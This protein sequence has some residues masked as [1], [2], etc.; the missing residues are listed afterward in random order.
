MTPPTS[1]SAASSSLRSMRPFS[2]GDHSG[3]PTLS[4]FCRSI[5]QPV[6]AARIVAHDRSPFIGMNRS[7]PSRPFEKSPHPEHGMIA[8]PEDA[9]P[10]G[11]VEDGAEHLWP[12][13]IGRGGGVVDNVLGQR[14][15]LGHQLVERQTASPMRQD[16]SQIGIR[17]QKAQQSIRRGGALARIAMTDRLRRMEKERPLGG[18]QHGGHIRQEPW[19]RDID[20]LGI[21]V[22]LADPGRAERQTALGL[23]GRIRR[24]RRHDPEPGQAT[25]ARSWRHRQ[26]SHCARG[27]VQDRARANR[28]RSPAPRL[29]RPWQ[30]LAQPRRSSSRMAPRRARRTSDLAG[31][32]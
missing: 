18:D 14:G 29:R 32:D 24:G 12:I 16:D 8:C 23:R 28:R 6:D 17:R 7:Q 20:A 10:A 15:D 9:L 31:S 21:G 27:K 30:T 3:I 4:T 11:D 25:V 19:L 22:Q 13:E 2:P 1:I 5:V 26:D